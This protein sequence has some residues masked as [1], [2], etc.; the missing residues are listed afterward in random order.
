MKKTLKLA[1]VAASIA[2]TAVACDP[3]KKTSGDSVDS[4]TVADSAK[5][6]SAAKV[7]SGMTDTTKKDSV[8]K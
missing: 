3:A 7:D 2:L 8:K 1:F 5:R 6:D 4:T